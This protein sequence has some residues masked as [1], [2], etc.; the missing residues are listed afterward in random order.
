MISKCIR[1]LGVALCAS[2]ILAACTET[3]G[4]ASGGTSIQ[5]SVTPLPSVNSTQSAGAKTFSN[6]LG[7]SITLTRV[8]LS[9]ANAELEDSCGLSFIA[10]AE[11]LFNFF[12]PGAHAHT[13]TT[14]TAT[15]EPHVIDLLAQDG[16]SINIGTVS[17]PVADY[18]GLHLDLLAADADTIGLPTGAGEPDMFGKTLYIE[19][20]YTLAGGGSGAIHIDTGAAL[21]GRDALLPALVSISSTSRSGIIETGINYDTWFNALDLSALETET[22]AQT[23]PTDISV[24]QLLQNVSA[25]IH[26]L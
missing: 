4:L 12:I 11:S 21:L 20:T 19:G 16:L 3:S 17:P 5:L 26:A 7:D 2:M 6:D 14:P 24:G 23:S 10:A 15:G 13:E 18:C 9:I 22:A 8:Y 25:S 1:R